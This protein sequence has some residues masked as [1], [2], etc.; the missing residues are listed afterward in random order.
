MSERE[1]TLPPAPPAHDDQELNDRVIAEAIDRW[2]RDLTDLGGRNSLIYPPQIRDAALN[3]T[4]SAGADADA[5]QRILS[6]Q[7]VALSECFQAERLADAAR[8]GR[9]LGAGSVNVPPLN[10]FEIDIR[11][12]LEA[13]GLKLQPQYGVSGYRIDFAAMHPDEP[14]RPI[15]AIEAD[16]AQYHSTQA[17]R[18][19]DRLSQDHLQRLGWRF[20]RIWSTEWFRNPEFEADR[21]LAAYQQ[22]LAADRTTASSPPPPP[23]ELPEEP[24][25]E[26]PPPPSRSRRPRILPGKK[27]DDYSPRQLTSIIEWIESDGRLRA[28]DELLVEAMQVLGFKRRDTKIVAALTQAIRRAR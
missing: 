20:H 8:R 17:A 16:G 4:P 5:V 7:R 9:K 27:I 28:E 11:D 21:A 22:A 26:P 18:D 15:L 6:G 25:E 19:R 24:P 13:R 3:L 2:V 14:G 1:P 10:P 23:K 12:R